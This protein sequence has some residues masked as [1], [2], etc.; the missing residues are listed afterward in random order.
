VMQI[1]GFSESAAAIQKLLEDSPLF[2][3]VQFTTSIVR[4]A[5][6]KDRFN[7]RASIEVRP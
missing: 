7:L 4:D 2:R 3:D 1:A 6:G 5:V